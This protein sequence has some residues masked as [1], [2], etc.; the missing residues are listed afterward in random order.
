MSLDNASPCAFSAAAI[1]SAV[2][3]LAA[4]IASALALAAAA[5]AVDDAAVLDAVPR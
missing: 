2:A 3:L 5:A 4:A 1:A